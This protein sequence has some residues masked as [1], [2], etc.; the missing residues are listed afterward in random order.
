M[1][2]IVIIFSIVI[3]LS[4]LSLY[5]YSLSVY[6][7]TLKPGDFTMNK[8][9]SFYWTY[10]YTDSELDKGFKTNTL[11]KHSEKKKG[12]LTYEEL[13]GNYEPFKIIENYYVKKDTLYKKVNN[14][15]TKHNIVVLKTP[16]KKGHA[17]KGT[18][19]YDTLTYFKIISTNSKFKIE[20][21][22]FKNLLKVRERWYGDES[23]YYKYYAKDIGLIKMEYVEDGKIF[24]T[25][26]VYKLKKK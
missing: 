16:L 12:W 8:D 17:W 13:Y 1:K 3:F 26:Y 7:K 21:K 6:A 9:Y 11:Y 24:K 15:G 25:E 10:F 14:D 5:N 4:T 19:Y 23:Y 22:T 18:S 2:K 20:N